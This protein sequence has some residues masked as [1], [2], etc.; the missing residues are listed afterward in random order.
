MTPDADREAQRVDGLLASFGELMAVTS[1]HAE[2]LAGH[3][4]DL[5]NLRGEMRDAAKDLTTALKAVGPTLKEMERHCDDAVD[6]VREDI[7]AEAKKVQQSKERLELS[8]LQRAG[9]LFAA[10]GPVLTAIA[11]VVK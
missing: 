4:R 7:A 5:G 9:L 6:K 1:A 10:C 8:W 3:D 2:R 11:M